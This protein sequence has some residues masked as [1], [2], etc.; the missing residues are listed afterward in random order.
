M[1]KGLGRGLSALFGDDFDVEQAGSALPGTLPLHRI[2]PNPDQ[3]RRDF[4]S[5]ELQT[6]ADSL[7]QHGML[8][9]VAVRDMGNGYYQIIAGER[10]WRAA[11]LAGFTELPVIVMEADDRRAAEL[12]L[13]ENLQRRDLNPVEAAR[14]YRSLMDAFGLTQEDASRRVGKSRSAVANALRLLSLPDEVLTMLEAGTLSPGHARAVLAVPNPDD[15]LP[16]ARRIVEEGLSVRQAEALAA[17]Q[18]KKPRAAPD[19]S[20]QPYWNA[21]QQTLS[22]ALGR[23]VRIRPGQRKGIVELEYYNLNDFQLLYEALQT[24]PCKENKHEQA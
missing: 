3:P 4:D 7:A 5:E 18:A 2:E 21:C 6:L 15:R 23:G 16:F 1:E 17:K 8:S 12:A 9:P 10:R 22:G 19:S 11:R 24:L 14:G 20:R 13:V